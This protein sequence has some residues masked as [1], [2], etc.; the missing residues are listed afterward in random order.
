MFKVLRLHLVLHFAVFKFS[1]YLTRTADGNGSSSEEGVK[2]G[3]SDGK[4]TSAEEMQILTREMAGF[5]SA[6]RL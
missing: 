6:S 1:P 5:P 2:E 3:G 4:M